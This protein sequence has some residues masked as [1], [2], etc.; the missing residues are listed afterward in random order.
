MC[1]YESYIKSG[2]SQLRMVTL[3]NKG[4]DFPRNQTDFAEMIKT[5]KIDEVLTKRA[6]QY[7]K[8]F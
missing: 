7:L 5:I 4:F 2:E 8:H 6:K 3:K 1:K